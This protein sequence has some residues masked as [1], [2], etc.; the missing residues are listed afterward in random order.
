[1]HVSMCVYACMCVCMFVYVY[2]YIIYVHVY[3]LLYPYLYGAS[4]PTG[5][6]LLFNLSN[7]PPLI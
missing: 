4:S 7:P 2:G 3:I 1:M 6:L 5:K